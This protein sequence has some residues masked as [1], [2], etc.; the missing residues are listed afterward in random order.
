MSLS[1][2]CDTS[3]HS[4]FVTNF[5]A[6][7]LIHNSLKHLRIYLNENFST[8]KFTSKLLNGLKYCMECYNGEFEIHNHSTYFISDI[9]L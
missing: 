7:G 6:Y 3:D 8:P 1:K 4:F 5:V 2:A 9:F